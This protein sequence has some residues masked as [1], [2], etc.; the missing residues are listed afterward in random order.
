MKV[1]IDRLLRE[2]QA[3][4]LANRRS[5]ERTHFVRPVLIDMTPRL[6]ERVTAFSRD[7]SRNAVGIVSDLPWEVGTIATLHIHSLSGSPVRVRS[8]VRW[9]EPYGKGWYLSGWRFLECSV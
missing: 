2:N 8:D 5:V 9:C 3:R 1:D 7:I 6:A 4:I